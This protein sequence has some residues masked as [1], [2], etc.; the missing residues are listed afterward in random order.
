MFDVS[1]NS[2]E[3]SLPPDYA[4]LKQLRVLLLSANQLHGCAQTHGY[5][6]GGDV[7]AELG[8]FVY[9]RFHCR[10]DPLRFRAWCLQMFDIW[11]GTSAL[12]PHCMCCNLFSCA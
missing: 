1:A 5:V 3:G 6:F 2:I 9:M 8:P 10:A 7:H 11:C 12:P 4:D